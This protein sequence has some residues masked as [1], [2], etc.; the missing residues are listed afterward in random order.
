MYFDHAATTQVSNRTISVMANS[1]AVD[2]GNPSSIHSFGLKTERAITLARANIAKFLCIDPKHLIF[3]SGAT[4][5]SNLVLKSVIEHTTPSQ[6]HMITTQIEHPSVLQIFKYYEMKGYKVTYLP[7]NACGLVNLEDLKKALTD[8]TFLVSIMMVNNEVGSIQK[9]KEMCAMTHQ[10]DK[11]I[12]FHTDAV[13]AFGKLPINLDQLTVDAASFSAHKLHGPKGIGLLYVK[14]PHKLHPLQVGGGQ[15]SN[16][17]SGTENVPGILGFSEAVVEFQEMRETYLNQ[18]FVLK[19]YC[20]DRLAQEFSDY[21][22]L[23]P[24]T[25]EHSHSIVSIAFK[26][27]RSE[28][29][30]HELEGQGIYVSSGSACSSHKKGAISHV[31]TAMRIPKAYT[32]GVIRI[33]FSGTQA[34]SQLEKAMDSMRDTIQNHREMTTRRR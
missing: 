12:F 21:I 14:Q 6:K 29:L 18:L 5:S 28:V 32:E 2:F 13:Q 27:V 3:T 9:I 11:K 33:S 16:L 7:V 25:D 31:V 23:S 34:L 8:E 30:V 10:F 19:K 1:M 22:L 15:E 4:E 26:N 24:L 17:R 20:L